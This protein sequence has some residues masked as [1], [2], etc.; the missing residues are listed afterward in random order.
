MKITSST[1]PA[2]TQ[3]RYSEAWLPFTQKLA[4][5][6]A[7]LEEDQYLV[8][9]AKDSN[10]FVQ[11]AAQGAFGLRAETISNHFLPA[12]QQ[13]TLDQDLELHCAGWEPPS[14]SPEISAPENDPDGSPNYYCDYPAPV[15]YYAVA[16]QAVYALSR[17]HKIPH[18]GFL[19]YE[20][21]ETGG[22]KIILS[23][24]GLKRAPEIPPPSATNIRGQLLAS[25]RAETGLSELD[26]DEQGDLSIIYGNVPVYLSIKGAPP[27]VQISSALLQHVEERARLLE[28][29]NELN[30][31]LNHLRLVVHDRTIFAVTHIPAAP[32]VEAHLIKAFREFCPT[33]DKL[34]DLLAV[35]FEGTPAGYVP[36]QSLLKH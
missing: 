11:F 21:F 2:V 5:A 14:G 31:G 15:D 28:R 20:A 35:E 34:R 18:P 7:T 8:I 12:D 23:E 1:S 25:I 30:G 6:L 32:Y 29:V 3:L 16:R 36:S 9:S 13:L 24:L 33:A 26:Y 4:T 19:Q 27:D 10:R 17:V 22:G